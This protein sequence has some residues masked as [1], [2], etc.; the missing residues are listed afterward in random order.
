MR[1]RYKI[2]ELE[3][4]Q[5][6]I[7]NKALHLYAYVILDNHFHI[8]ASFPHLSSTIASLRKYTTKEIIEQLR[9]DKKSWLLNQ[10]KFYKK[11]H[12]KDSLYQVWQEGTH[13]E[14]IQT[15]KMLFQK[16]DYPL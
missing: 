10:L 5:F 15:E 12:N 6:C 8:I 14:L 16:I 2:Y 11:K 9:E 3:S 13:P 4:L 1:D 7:E